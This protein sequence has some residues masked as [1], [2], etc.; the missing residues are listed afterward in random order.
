MKPDTENIKKATEIIQAKNIRKVR[1]DLDGLYEVKG[2][3]GVY[4]LI[5]DLF[6]SCQQFI[7]RTIHKQQ[8]ICYHLLAVQMADKVEEVEISA[9]ELF[10]MLS[11]IPK[12]ENLGS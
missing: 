9:Q 1:T 6:C 3:T 4:L 12:V 7:V 11:K 2:K 10:N 5:K 8:N